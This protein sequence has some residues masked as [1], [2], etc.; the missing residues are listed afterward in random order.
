MNIKLKVKFDE[1][2]IIINCR[3]RK[4][5]GK[6]DLSMIKKSVTKMRFHQSDVGKPGNL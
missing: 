6:I 5:N 3:R 1:L 4:S 2:P